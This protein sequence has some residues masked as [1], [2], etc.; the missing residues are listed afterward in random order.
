MLSKRLAKFIPRGHL[1]IIAGGT[2][3]SIIVLY[4]FKFTACSNNLDERRK[5]ENKSLEQLI[6]LRKKATLNCRKI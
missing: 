1:P 3:L 2:G 4:D 6:S 5:L